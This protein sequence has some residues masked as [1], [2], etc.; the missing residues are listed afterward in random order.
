MLRPAVSRRLVALALS[1]LLLVTQQWGTLHLLSHGLHGA[2]AVAS[3]SDHTPAAEPALADAGD[4]LCQLCLVLAAL[5]AAA[6]PALWRWLARPPRAATPPAPPRPAAALPA[7][8]PWHA[9]GP[10]ALH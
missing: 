8:A 4:A 5:G 6:M 1:L 7:R 10:P 9:R 2:A 3:A